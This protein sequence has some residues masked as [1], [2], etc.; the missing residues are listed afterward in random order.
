M[1]EVQH[2]LTRSFCY[3]IVAV[4]TARSQEPAH[5]INNKPIVYL[6]IFKRVRS[7]W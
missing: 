1:T 6:F 4:V 2:L 7:T 3:V 5:S